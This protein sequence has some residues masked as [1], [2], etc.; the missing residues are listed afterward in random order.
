[1]LQK[2]PNDSLVKSTIA[3]EVRFFWKLIS[4]L[5]PLGLE[6]MCLKVK[7]Q[8]FLAIIPKNIADKL[9]VTLLVESTDS[10]PVYLTIQSASGIG[11]KSP[12]TP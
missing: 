8:H 9:D 6:E 3:Y 12:D 1:M 10:L 11:K 7:I 4:S 2:K 5:F